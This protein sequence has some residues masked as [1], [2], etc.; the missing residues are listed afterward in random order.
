[1][2]IK[3][4]QMILI[5]GARTASLYIFNLHGVD[6]NKQIKI[7]KTFFGFLVFF[8]KKKTNEAMKCINM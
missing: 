4:E 5:F 3:N 6:V 8:L 7:R 1:M 2:K